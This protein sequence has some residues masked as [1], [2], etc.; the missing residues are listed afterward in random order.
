VLDTIAPLFSFGYGLS[1]TTFA[2]SNL[3]LTASHMPATGTTSASIDVRNTGARSGDEVVQ[4]YIRDEVSAATRPIKELRG[5]QRITLAPGEAR[6]VS[7]AI[8][9][10]LLAYHGPDMKRVVEPGVFQIMVGG[11]SADLQLIALTV[12]PPAHASSTTSQS[13][14]RPIKPR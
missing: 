1:Y 9:G 3:R 2:Y 12:D 5:F 13:T 7:F 6:T 11:N 10:D 8:R 4:L 14:V